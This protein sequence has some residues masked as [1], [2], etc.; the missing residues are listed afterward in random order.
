MAAINTTVNTATMS[1]AVKSAFNITIVDEGHEMLLVERLMDI[2][3]IAVPPKTSAYHMEDKPTMA[4]LCVS[5]LHTSYANIIH[6]YARDGKLFTGVKRT[7]DNPYM[8]EGVEEDTE[9][10]L[11]TAFYNARVMRSKVA[12]LAKDVGWLNGFDNHP[13]PFFMDIREWITAL[14]VSPGEN[15]WN[16]KV[17]FY[18]AK[19][20]KV[21]DIIEFLNE[22]EEDID[23]RFKTYADAVPLRAGDLQTGE[24]V[25]TRFERAIDIVSDK[26]SVEF[27]NYLAKHV[28]G[29]RFTM[30]NWVLMVTSDFM[31]KTV[32]GWSNLTM[33][34][35]LQMKKDAERLL[36][37]EEAA[38]IER[39][40]N[41]L[42]LETMEIMASVSKAKAE[43]ASMDA[44]IAKRMSELMGTTAP[45]TVEEKPKSKAK[46]KSLMPRIISGMRAA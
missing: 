4:S 25:R 1:K 21:G 36:E 33:F 26:K 17:A 13:E 14:P 39:E 12:L 9:E 8:D 3:N 22:P 19:M 34:K 16:K 10:E 30:P 29:D 15:S 37:L 28:E 43:G 41:L 2:T 7:I 27:I 5:L 35:V 31:R 23:S 11:E 38:K 6:A 20:P 46:A 24:D 42:K 44:F 18:V 45:D 40:A 32:K